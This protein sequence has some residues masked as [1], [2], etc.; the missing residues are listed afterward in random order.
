VAPALRRLTPLA[1]GYAAYVAIGGSVLASNYESGTA[2]PFLFFG[3]ALFPIFVVARAW[4]A[5]GS[6]SMSARIGRAAA[7]VAGVAS[8]AFLAYVEGT[9]Q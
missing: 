3:A 5:A 2:R 4:S 6:S 8:A 1:L 7:C 9:K